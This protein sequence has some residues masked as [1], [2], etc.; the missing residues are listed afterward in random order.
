[1]SARKRQRFAFRPSACEARLEDR[2]VLAAGSATT[3]ALGPGVVAIVPPPAAWA[4]TLGPP[5]RPGIATGGLASRQG[6]ARELAFARQI[7]RSYLQQ[8]RA[9]SRDLQQVIGNQA[10]QLF[11]AG[12]PTAQQLSD[13]NAFVDGA[14]NATAF[15][16]SSQAALLPNAG[17]RLVGSIQDAL[18]G[19]GRQSLM[20]Q[21]QGQAFASRNTGSLQALQNAIG[22]GINRSFQGVN[23][24]FG[25]FFGTTPLLRVS[26]DPTT[27]QRIPLQQFLGQQVINQFGQSLGALNQ[28]LPTFGNTSLF[29]NGAT[30]ADLAARQAFANQANS[31]LG[32]AAFQLGNNL[33]L[34]PGGTGLI[35]QLQPG[36]FGTTPGSTSLLGSVLNLPTTAADF[37]TAATGLFSNSFANLASPLG[38]FFGLPSTQTFNLPTGNF[39][40]VFGPT[41][42]GNDFFGGFNGG[43]GTGIPGFGTAPTAFNTNFGTGFGNLIGTLNPTFGFNIPTDLTGLGFPFLG[44]T[45]VGGGTTGIGGGT[46]GIGGGTTGIGGGTTGIGGGTTGI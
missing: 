38:T 29:A 31:A 5:V 42:T 24:S 14:I 16:V 21:I 37:N 20:S 39:A 18:L 44:T 23:N 9:A 15:R 46:T 7:Q 36:L 13:F 1:M 17:S 26:V 6:V 28:A 8:V 34:F 43:F 40:N 12:T 4:S 10:S 19:G 30:T 35:P 11:A 32:L 22:Q 2:V 45:G 41:F 33:A 3:V 27:G 25:S